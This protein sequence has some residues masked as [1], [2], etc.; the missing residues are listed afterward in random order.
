MNIL[1]S[2]PLSVQA[3]VLLVASNAFCFVRPLENLAT[4]Y[5]IFRCPDGVGSE[6]RPPRYTRATSL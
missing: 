4:A 5:F 2:I 6:P 1:Q 3:I